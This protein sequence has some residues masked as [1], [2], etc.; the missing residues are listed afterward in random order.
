LDSVKGHSPFLVGAEL[1][2]AIP[3]PQ[4]FTE[5]IEE[6]DGQFALPTAILGKG[7]IEK[8]HSQPHIMNVKC[9]IA[10]M[11]CRGVS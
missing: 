7:H 2:R 1:Q 9:G 3:T 11:A 5:S 8:T 6:L 4:L 10:E